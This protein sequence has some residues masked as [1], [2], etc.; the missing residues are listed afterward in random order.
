MGSCESSGGL[1]EFLHPDAASEAPAIQWQL[2]VQE[3]VLTA[4]R[5]LRRYGIAHPFGTTR[6]A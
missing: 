2:C 4:S 3:M 6:P 5:R 1:L